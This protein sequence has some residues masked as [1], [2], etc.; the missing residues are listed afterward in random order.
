M[1]NALGLLVAAV[2]AVIGAIVP[3]L[4]ALVENLINKG[5]G[6]KFFAKDPFG[7]FIARLFGLE[8]YTQGPESL[9]RELSAASEQMDVIVRQIQEYTKGREQAV[10]ELESQLGLLSEQEQELKQ[11]IQGLQS[12]P[13]PAAEY[14]AQLVHKGEKRNALRDYILFLLGVLVSTGVTVLIRKLGWA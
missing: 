2:S 7:Q 9:F 5:I 14:F 8:R 11:R 3:A 6:E 4:N 13:L 12:V 1:E 10:A